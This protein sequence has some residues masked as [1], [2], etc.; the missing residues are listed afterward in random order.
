MLP[1]LFACDEQ[2]EEDLDGSPAVGFVSIGEFEF[3]NLSGNQSQTIFVPPENVDVVVKAS[4][5]SAIEQV[6]LFLDGTQVASISDPVGVNYT[7]EVDFPPNSGEVLLEVEATDDA[8]N[9]SARISQKVT[10]DSQKPS[11]N[12]DLLVNSSEIDVSTPPLPPVD[13]NDSVTIIATPS[14][15][16][17]DI[18]DIT[19]ELKISGVVINNT[20]TKNLGKQVYPLNQIV[21]FNLINVIDVSLKAIDGSGNESD[22]INFSI[23][24]RE[25]TT[26]PELE[27]PTVSIDTANIEPGTINNP[28]CTLA[29]C[30]EDTISIPVR[31]EDETGTAKVT[32]VVDSEAL[33]KA[34]ISTVTSFPYV[35]TIN[36]LEYPNNDKLILT[37]Q[38]V[39]DA[40]VGDDSA[41]VTI[42]VFNEAPPAV[43]SI[44]SPA[45]GDRVSD[46]LPVGVT[47]SQLTNSEYTLD[48]NGDN[49]VDASAA[50][51]GQEG[52]HIEIIDFTGEIV[53]EKRLSDT[54]IPG[55]VSPTR[56][57]SYE[58]AEGFDT[59][60]L[61]NDTYTMRVTVR[62]RLKDSPDGQIDLTLVRKIQI[63]TDNTSRV[64]PALLILSPTNPNDS[65][66]TIRSP[67]NAYV[68]ALATDNTGLAFVELRVFTGTVDDD[69]TPSRYVYASAGEVATT[70]SLPI[71]FNADPYLVNGNNYKVR[72]VA[73]DVDG[74]RTFQDIRINLQRSQA[75]PGYEL[76]RIGPIQNEAI[77]DTIPCIQIR[78]PIIVNEIYSLGV[79]LDFVEDVI[80][81]N[82]T[83]VG[84]VSAY[85]PLKVGRPVNPGD[86]F[87]HFVLRAGD[88]AYRP[89]TNTGT[90]ETGFSDGYPVQG[91]YYYVSQV[92]TADGDIYITN[93]EAVAVQ[94]PVGQQ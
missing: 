77:F 50:G 12:V 1:F 48:L 54:T 71:N 26:E 21:N 41:P 30:Y 60:R 76:R 87:D 49:V 39:S 86:R 79:A 52:I 36:T 78:H 53:D 5:N 91:T 4:D 63:D 16:S 35:F 31:V 70:V 62:A 56:G 14:D 90:N 93:G 65:V 33:G 55:T 66:K 69:A 13:V 64:P 32:L 61:A 74:N 81:N 75:D 28:D 27:L 17:S 94:K 19:V 47:I 43:L 9:K 25:R 42:E 10:V 40:G 59:N 58:T 84:Q 24:V 8:G 89:I 45:D 3:S 51:A 34:P 2:N 67:I 38:V 92:C 46:F 23:T 88:S 29:A 20:A 6:S 44:N 18:N 80:P 85:P 68:T 7:F 15:D 22:P 11:L 57:G 37:A 82:C 73:E 72:V 83:G